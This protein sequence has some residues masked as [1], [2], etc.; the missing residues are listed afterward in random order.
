[1]TDNCAAACKV[2]QILCNDIP[3]LHEFY[4]MHHLCNV[5][6]RSTEKDITS[7]IN[8]ILHVSLENID[9]RIWVSSSISAVIRAVEKKFSLSA[10]CPKVHGDMFGE[11]I[12][13][14][15]PGALLLYVERAAGSRQDLCTEGCLPIIMNY[16]YYLEFLYWM[17][18]KTGNNDKA[19]LLQRNLF[20]VLGSVEMIALDR[21]LSIIHIYVCMPFHWLAGKTHRLK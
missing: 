19:S 5:W 13:Q 4:C 15:Y 20:V 2:R 18:K 12:L 9:P 1:M 10:N 14:L 11:W 8:N 6:I 17:L 16:P 3:G 7:D 21:L